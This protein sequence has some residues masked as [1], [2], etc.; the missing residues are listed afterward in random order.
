MIDVK[1][2]YYSMARRTIIIKK[3]SFTLSVWS[4]EPLLPKFLW[5]SAI[6]SLPSMFTLIELPFITKIIIISNNLIHQNC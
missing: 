5:L 2:T 3:N 6:F 4:G 1:L